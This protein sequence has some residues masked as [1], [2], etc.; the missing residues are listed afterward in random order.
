M[1]MSLLNMAVWKSVPPG[2]A[3]RTWD[4]DAVRRLCETPKFHRPSL[5]IWALVS[6][7]ALFRHPC[8]RFTVGRLTA[9]AT[10]QA[11]TGLATSSVVA[12]TK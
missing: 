11:T 5:A 4:G 3:S 6:G 12:A 7:Q 10:A 9:W 8:H 1:A 2:V